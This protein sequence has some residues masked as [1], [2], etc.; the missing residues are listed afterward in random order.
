[1]RFV[2]RSDELVDPKHSLL[3]RWG[4]ETRSTTRSPYNSSTYRSGLGLYQ[5]YQVALIER[6]RPR[7]DHDLSV[8]S[9]SSIYPNLSL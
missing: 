2:I 6:S 9:R 7:T 8:Y 5:V 3:R 1:M 4:G